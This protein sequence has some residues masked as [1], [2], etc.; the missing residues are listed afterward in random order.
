MDMLYLLK[1]NFKN[2]LFGLLITGRSFH[3]LSSEEYAQTQYEALNQSLLTQKFQGLPPN[4]F[5]GL[6]AYGTK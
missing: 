3:N 6:E 4:T 2:T 1:E 5:Y